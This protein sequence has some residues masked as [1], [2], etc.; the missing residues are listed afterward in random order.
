MVLGSRDS[1]YIYHYLHVGSVLRKSWWLSPSNIQSQLFP[2]QSMEHPPTHSLHD[3]LSPFPLELPLL[4]S[5]LVCLGSG[6]NFLSSLSKASKVRILQPQDLAIANK[7]T[8]FLEPRF[9]LCKY[10][11]IWY[12]Y[13]STIAFY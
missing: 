1:M 2:R 10:T 13:V 4:V 9:S 6:F 11:K 12:G 8:A 5:S 3:N 7:S